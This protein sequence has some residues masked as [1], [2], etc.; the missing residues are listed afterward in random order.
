MEEC[1]VGLPAAS[2]LEDR[3]LLALALALARYKLHAAKLTPSVLS[4]TM[5]NTCLQP[6]ASLQPSSL[7]VTCT[8]TSDLRNLCDLL[9]FEILNKTQS[10]L[11]KLPEFNANNT[12]LE[13]ER[14]R[15]RESARQSARESAI[16]SERERARETES[17]SERARERRVLVLRCVTEFYIYEGVV[18]GPIDSSNLI[19]SKAFR[20]GSQDQKVAKTCRKSRGKTPQPPSSSYH[21]CSVLD[22]NEPSIPVLDFSFLLFFKLKKLDETFDF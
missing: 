8:R 20:Q 16:E 4:T 6:F 21:F 18:Q 11:P 2:A 1:V 17:T 19:G 12:R 7:R 13:R 22:F 14:A 3:S 10:G 9:L 15:E 5:Y